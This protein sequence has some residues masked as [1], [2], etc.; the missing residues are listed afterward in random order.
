MNPDRYSE[1]FG[2]VALLD[3]AVPDATLGGSTPIQEEPLQFDNEAALAFDGQ[4]ATRARSEEGQPRLST[5]LFGLLGPIGSMPYVYT[6]MV[7]RASRSNEEGLRD[8]FGI[9]SHR[10]TSLMYRAWRK[11]RLWLEKHPG[12]RADQQHKFSRMLE[13]FTG[14]AAM[15]QRIAWLDFER[16]RLL[17]C[18]DLF[19]RRVRSADGLRRLLNRQFGMSF[20]IDEFVGNWEQLPDEAKSR[21]VPGGSNLRLA[22]NTIIGNRTWQ[23]QSTFRV[24]IRHPSAAQYRSLQPNSESLRLLQLAIRS[25][26]TAELSFRIHIVVAGSAVL[27]GTLDGGEHGGAMLGWNTL[28]GTPDKTRDYSFSICRDYNESRMRS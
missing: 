14:T 27:P 20:E 3:D 12:A 19:A 24:V 9:F 2:L 28:A 21:F 23:V 26:C 25:Y 22:Y 15:P 13:G 8:F 5:T 17:S 4:A 11:S 1:L 18:S 10:S 7:A 6:E 16:E